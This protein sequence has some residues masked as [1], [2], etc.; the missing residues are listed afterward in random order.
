MCCF[1]VGVV[2]NNAQ[3]IVGNNYLGIL[4][5][6]FKFKLVLSKT[7]P[8]KYTLNWEWINFPGIRVSLFFSNIEITMDFSLLSWQRDKVKTPLTNSNQFQSSS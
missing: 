8:G 5:N 1:K 6:L 3:F 7:M 4:V 2:K